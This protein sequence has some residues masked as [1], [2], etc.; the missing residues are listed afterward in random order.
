[1][2]RIDYPEDG[3][4]NMCSGSINAC[5]G[6]ISAS[7]SESYFDIPEDFSYRSYLAGLNGTLNS[8]Q[9][10]LNSIDSCLQHTNNS[11]RSLSSN[12]EEGARR[13]EVNKIPERDR[14]ITK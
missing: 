8:F 5:R 6:D 11:Y 13:I 14:L 7:I 10:E 9:S 1:M 4:Y 12:L 2:S 3:I